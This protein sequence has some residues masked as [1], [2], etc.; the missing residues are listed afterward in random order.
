[1]MKRKTFQTLGLLPIDW[2]FIVMASP[3]WIPTVAA[4]WAWMKLEDVA[5]KVSRWRNS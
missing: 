5:V 4:V 3:I 2:V 1:M